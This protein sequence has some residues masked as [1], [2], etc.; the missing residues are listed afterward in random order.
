M[1]LYKR[2]SSRDLFRVP[3][4]SLLLEHR[5]DDGLDKRDSSRDLFRVPNVSLLLQEVMCNE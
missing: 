5:E 4:V 3:N 1:R 2:D